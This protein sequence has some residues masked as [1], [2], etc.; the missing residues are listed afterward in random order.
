MKQLRFGVLGCSRVAQ[1]AAIPA[2]MQSPNTT[3]SAIGSR[4]EEAARTCAEKFNIG[5]SGD[6]ADVVHHPD[7]DAVYISLP[8]SLHEEWTIKAA[9][10]GK[11]VWCEK[12]AALTYE[13]AKNI[14]DAAA[15]HGVHI[16]EGFPFLNHPQHR[17]VKNIIANGL[18]G[19]PTT[20]H[21]AFSYPMPDDAN[22]RLDANL[23][24]G[25]YADAAVYPIRASRMLFNDEPESVF[26]HL[27]VD[28]E[29]GIDV[30]ADLILTYPGNKTAHLSTAFGA[31][32]QSSYSVLGSTGSVSLDRA[33][34]VPPDKEVSVHL[35]RNDETET[36]RVAPANQFVLFAKDFSD[37]ALDAEQRKRHADDLL[38]Q[39][40]VFEAGI[41][42]NEEGCVVALAEIA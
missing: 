4:S 21:G 2:L 6:Y 40:R 39:A 20:F 12:P 9:T 37:M 38:K 25:V 22:I 36:I 10:A 15:K 29:R 42:S 18:I 14:A 28:P 30:K 13:A 7:V 34:A 27:T 32:F 16:R 11:H 23:G 5:I 41:K 33:Y 31:Y 19:T 8:N 1:K 26:C 3:V 17:Q 35:H 24:G